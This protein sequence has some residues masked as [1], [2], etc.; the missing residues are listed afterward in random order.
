MTEIFLVG[1][2]DSEKK[3]SWLAM[4][5]NQEEATKLLGTLEG[6]TCM[7]T[8]EVKPSRRKRK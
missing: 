3:N 1:D 6:A 8:V 5:N 7:K 2:K 4:T